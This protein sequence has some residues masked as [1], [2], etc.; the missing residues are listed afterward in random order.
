VLNY[1]YQYIRYITYKCT[2]KNTI[3]III[4]VRFNGVLINLLL[5][6]IIIIKFVGCVI[7]VRKVLKKESI[8]RIKCNSMKKKCV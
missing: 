3:I 7:A 6:V 2:A 5:L 4:V 8:G 1:Q